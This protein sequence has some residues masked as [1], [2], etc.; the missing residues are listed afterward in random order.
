MREYAK[1]IFERA[2]GH[3]TVSLR[4]AARFRDLA[5]ESDRALRGPDQ[6][7]WLA[8]MEAEHDNLRRAIRFALDE[9]LVSLALQLV[10]GAAWF[11]FMGGH[12]KESQ[13]WLDEALALAGDGSPAERAAAIYRTAAIQVIRVNHEAV[14]PMIHEALAICKRVGD[15]YGE[16]WCHHLLGHA[17][18]FQLGGEGLEQLRLS[19]RLFA[20]ADCAWEV[21]WS[22][23]FIGGA[24][25]EIGQGD[26][27]SELLLGSVSSFREMGDLWQTAYGLFVTGATFLAL[28]DWGPE[29]ARPYLQRCQRLADEIGD[30]VWAAHAVSRLAVAANLAGFADPEPLFLDA[31]ERHRLIGDDACLDLMSRLGFD[32]A[33]GFAIAAPMAGD[34]LREWSRDWV[35]GRVAQAARTRR[36]SA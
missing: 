10:A 15:R 29:A 14:L 12:W 27:G 8:R 34:E 5:A 18:A 24:L 4:H 2:P 19:R 23:R 1:E 28:P 31:M 20:E 36:E 16:A 21:A 33:Q 30:R 11:W 6:M 22:D 25:C 9:G 26:A 35:V 3:D 13:T 32:A 7:E 17:A